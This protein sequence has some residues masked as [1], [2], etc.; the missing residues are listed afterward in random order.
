MNEVKKS[1]GSTAYTSENQKFDPRTKQVIAALNYGKRVHGS[2]VYYGESYLLLKPNLKRDAIYFAGDT[3]G[4][5]GA[6]EQASYDYLATL[7]LHAKPGL[8]QLLVATCLYKS[9]MT[10]TADAGDL[11]EAHIFSTVYFSRD[12]VALY[13]KSTTDRNVLANA[14]KFCNKRG[15]KLVQNS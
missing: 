8:R 3:F 7:Y 13:L 9:S 4:C 14:K 6:H 15:I 10:D 11:V 1:D 5:Q 2:C 12:V